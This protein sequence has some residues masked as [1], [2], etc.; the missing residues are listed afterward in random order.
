MANQALQF[1]VA[2]IITVKCTQC[3]H[4]MQGHSQCKNTKGELVIWEYMYYCV[5][6][7]RLPAEVAQYQ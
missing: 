5:L 2:S 6:C 3:I 7:L 1:K 4:Y